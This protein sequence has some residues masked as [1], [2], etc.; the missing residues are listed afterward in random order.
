VE[1]TLTQKIE[2]SR[3]ILELKPDWDEELSK[4]CS[5][6]AWKKAVKFLTRESQQ[7][8][9]FPVP[10]ILLGPDGSIDLYWKTTNFELLVNIPEDSKSASYYGESKL[11]VFKG[12][13]DSDSLLPG[14][15]VWFRETA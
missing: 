8:L 11:G 1:S 14:L 3:W 5:K 4:T 13:F 2:S 12:T 15:D 7:I 6:S 10:D 9:E